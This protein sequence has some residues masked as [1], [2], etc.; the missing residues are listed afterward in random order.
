M[1]AFY[2]NLRN[3]A[4]LIRDPEPYYF[5]TAQAAR[6]ATVKAMRRIMRGDVGDKTIEIADETGHA[7]AVVHRYDAMPVRY[8]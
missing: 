6:D 7:I 2:L 8:P 4:R 1:A 5:A 3:G